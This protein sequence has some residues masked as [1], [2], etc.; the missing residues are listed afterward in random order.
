MLKELYKDTEDRMDKALEAVNREMTGVRTGKATPKM[1]DGIKVDYYGT[2]TALNQLASIGTPD[3]RMLVIQPWEQTIIPEIVKAIQKADLGL[4]PIAEGNLVRLPIPPLNEERRL[5][6]GRLVKKLG[7]DGKIAIRNIRRDAN[8][9]L[10]KAEKDSEITK[11]ELK[12]AQK[13]VQDFT[14]K[15]TEQISEIIKLKEQE[16]MEI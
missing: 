13:Q 8:E 5:E 7:E 3:P 16:V 9:K 6:M 12:T 1:L 10:K 15:H 14:D 11:D 2:A 4:N